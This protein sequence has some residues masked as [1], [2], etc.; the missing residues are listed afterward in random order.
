[1]CQHTIWVPCLQAAQGNLTWVSVEVTLY[2]FPN[3]LQFD[4]LKGLI[5]MLDCW[6]AAQSIVNQICHLSYIKELQKFRVHRWE[7]AEKHSLEEK[8]KNGQL[9]IAVSFWHL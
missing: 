8:G 7:G 2:S 6:Q 3:T 4:S 1:M 5:P 9:D